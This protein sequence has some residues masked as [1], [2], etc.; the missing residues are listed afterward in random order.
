M[1][2]P[3][4]LHSAIAKSLRFACARGDAGVLFAVGE[5]ASLTLLDCVFGKRH[6]SLMG[7]LSFTAVWQCNL[8]R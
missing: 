1:D 3:H 5:K 6:Y 7:F 4:C 8:S 2:F